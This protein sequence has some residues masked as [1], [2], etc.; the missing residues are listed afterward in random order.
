[1]ILK[2]NQDDGEMRLKYGGI[3]SYFQPNKKG[4]RL[5]TT[6][7]LFGE[8]SLVDRGEVFHITLKGWYG[9]TEPGS[10]NDWR[11]AVLLQKLISEAEVIVTKEAAVGRER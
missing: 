4:G 5:P 8:K 6:S 1:M 9:V 2:H 10:P 3:I 11:E 7:A